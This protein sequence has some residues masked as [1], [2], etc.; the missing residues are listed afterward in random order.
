MVAV[1]TGG[2]INQ[3]IAQEVTTSKLEIRYLARLVDR[4]LQYEVG[5][6]QSFS[7]NADLYMH[8]AGSISPLMSHSTQMPY[9]VPTSAEEI[10]HLYGR[11]TGS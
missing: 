4:S 10:H 8:M 6:C 2:E 9:K 1:H 5:L 3:T 11:L 7:I